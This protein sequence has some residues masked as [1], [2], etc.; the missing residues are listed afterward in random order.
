MWNKYKSYKQYAH[1]SH[2]YD[3]ITILVAI[4]V[5]CYALTGLVTPRSPKLGLTY[6]KT[7]TC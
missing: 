3:D 7:E 5:S 2:G 4:V 1:S 6:L